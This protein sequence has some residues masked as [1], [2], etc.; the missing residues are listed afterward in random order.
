[1]KTYNG[2]LH[3]EDKGV[4]ALYNAALANAEE[5]FRVSGYDPTE[6]ECLGE[7]IALHFRWDATPIM[8]AFANALED[9]NFHTHARTVRGWIEDPIIDTKVVNG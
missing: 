4:P 3:P 5:R 6:A 1:M 8:Q 2:R 7:L 9:A